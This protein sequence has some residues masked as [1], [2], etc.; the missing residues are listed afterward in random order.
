MSRATHR[1]GFRHFTFG[2]WREPGT[3]VDAS[4]W[5][6]RGVLEECGYLYPLPPEEQVEKGEDVEPPQPPGP[7][8][9]P[10]RDTRRERGKEP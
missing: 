5:P 1:V 9:R 2:E 10:K 3:L 4:T 8:G 6:N 7:H